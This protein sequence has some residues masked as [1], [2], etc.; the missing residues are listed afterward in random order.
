M[1]GAFL[2][3]TLDSAQ[4]GCSCWAAWSP[5]PLQHLQQTLVRAQVLCQLTNRG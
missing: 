5:T 3:L 2:V 1:Q 4:L